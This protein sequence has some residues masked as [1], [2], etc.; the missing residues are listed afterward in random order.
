MRKILARTDSEGNRDLP[1]SHI[2]RNLSIPRQIAFR[3]DN[4]EWNL[5]RVAPDRYM[6]IL[7]ARDRTRVLS[8]GPATLVATRTI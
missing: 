7:R 4:D 2:P 3:A 5:A 6:L 1:D 8:A